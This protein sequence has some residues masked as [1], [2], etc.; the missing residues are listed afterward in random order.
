M[1]PL[2][3]GRLAYAS[4]WAVNRRT[5]S[6]VKHCLALLVF[7]S[8]HCQLAASGGDVEAAAL[9]DADGEAG[10]AEDLGEARGCFT[11]AWRAVVADG[12]VERNQVDLR[13]NAAEKLC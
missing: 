2:H 3:A 5:L 9:A 6:S 7:R 4:G 13:R 11:A 12:R 10:F 1:L 8:R